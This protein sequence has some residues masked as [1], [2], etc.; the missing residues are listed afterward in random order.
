VESLEIR[1][2]SGLQQRFGRLPIN[3]SIRITEGE[4]AW[5]LVYHRKPEGEIS[6]ANV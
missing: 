3:T 4:S 5:E 1:W 6:W 2:P